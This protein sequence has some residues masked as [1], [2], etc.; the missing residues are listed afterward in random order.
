MKWDLA[1]AAIQIH[2]ESDPDLNE[3][4]GRRHTLLLAVCQTP[5][6]NFLHSVNSIREEVDTALKF[7]I[8]G[9]SYRN[10]ALFHRG[11]CKRREADHVAGR[12]NVGNFGLKELVNPDAPPFI[13]LDARRLKAKPTDRSR[14]PNAVQCFIGDDVLA[15]SQQE[16][17][18]LRPPVLVQLDSADLFSSRTVTRFSRR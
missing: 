11:R 9:M 7:G 3:F 8:E 5:D 12:V 15:T 14:A 6:P 2:L 1:P 4:D 13:G 17:D 16:L 18:R 10:A